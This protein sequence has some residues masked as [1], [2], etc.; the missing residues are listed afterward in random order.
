MCGP[1]PIGREPSAWPTR[2]ASDGLS[3]QATAAGE[4]GAAMVEYALMVALIGAAL[5][6][7]VTDLGTSIGTQFTSVSNAI[8]GS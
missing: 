3:T 6:T 1:K 8:S 5:A 2:R 7:V 4:D